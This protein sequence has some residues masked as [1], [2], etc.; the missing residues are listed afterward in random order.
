MNAQ[1]VAADIS[2]FV[3]DRV[4]TYK[5]LKGGIVFV[6]SLPKNAT[7]KVLRRVLRDEREKYEGGSGGKVLAKL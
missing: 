3:S 4:S 1:H 7:G 2:K 6:D 5:R